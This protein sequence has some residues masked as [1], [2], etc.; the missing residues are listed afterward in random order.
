M[1]QVLVGGG[2]HPDVHMQGFSAANGLKTL[3]LQNAQYF[4]LGI[5]GHICNFIEK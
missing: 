3:L 2:N 4:C 1:F 5:H